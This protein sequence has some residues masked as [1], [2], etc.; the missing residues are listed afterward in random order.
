MRVLIV[1]DDVR[2]V[3]ALINILEPRGCVL[4]VARNGQEALDALKKASETPGQAFD[5]VLMDVMMPG[6]DGY[7]TTQVI[8]ALGRFNDLP[9][10]SLTAKA[11]SGDREKSLASGANDY[12]TKPVDIEALLE[13]M[14]RHA[15]AR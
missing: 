14:A 12:I 7:E 10:I 5:L 13:M 11:M 1:E 9:I 3:Y 8:R 4:T 2:N 6:M 15:G